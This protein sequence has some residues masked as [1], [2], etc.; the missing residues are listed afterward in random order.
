MM[1]LV[2]LGHWL[3]EHACNQN[4]VQKYC[5]AA[6]TREARRALWIGCWWML[7]PWIG[8]SSWVS[9]RRGRLRA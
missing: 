7:P 4:T 8:S 9:S 6:S 2:G 3:T 5:A 1:L